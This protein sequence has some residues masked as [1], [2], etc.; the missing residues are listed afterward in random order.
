M[1]NR[2]TRYLIL[3]A[4]I[5]LTAAGGLA[6]LNYVAD[7]YGIYH[8]GR[9]GDWVKSRPSIRLLERLHKAHAIRD[10][11]AETL[12]LGNSR[13]IVGLDPQH[14]ALPQPGYNLGIGAAD[15]YECQRYL[16]HAIALHRPQ[17]VLLA[18]DK[19]MFTA[20]AAPEGDFDEARLSVRADGQPNPAWQRADVP[21]T[22]FSL[23]AVLASA[24]TLAARG[25]RVTYAHGLR[26]EALM[27]PYLSTA[28]VL[29][30]NERWKAMSR[31]FELLDA[32]GHNAQFDA[33]RT[34]LRL[35]TSAGI[36]I[37]VFTNP[38]HAAM[39]DIEYGDGD[40]FGSWLQQVAAVIAEESAA[41]GRAIPFWNF[42]GY[43]PITTEPFPDKSQPKSTLQ[44][45]WEISHYRKPIGDLILSRVMGHG[46]PRLEAL[47]TFGR[48]VTAE[49]AAQDIQRIAAER[50][51]WK[52]TSASQP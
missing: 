19:G 23:N 17:L 52:A 25:P 47:P 4:A 22:L 1:K 41:G 26:D 39:L 12:L 30:E 14:P 16:Q 6:A 37:R 7:P 33:F 31:K 51:Q 32:T 27:K 35:C 11:K 46:D 44:N 29:V 42:Y 24:T 50:G 18:I 20:D 15:I 38:L 21:D 2:W 49:T 3:L 34:I 28:K 5:A 36:E 8:Y 40:G 43:N 48:R 9:P 10:A 13:V 45:Y